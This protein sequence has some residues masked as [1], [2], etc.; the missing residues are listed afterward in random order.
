[1]KKIISLLLIVTLGLLFTL[2]VNAAITITV[3]SSGKVTNTGT[4]SVINVESTDVFLAYKI[5]DVKYDATSNIISY[6]FTDSFAPYAQ[7]KN[8]TVDSYMNLTTGNIHTGSTQTNSTLDALISGYVNYIK[9][10]NITGT[11]MNVTSTTASASLP[12]G[13]YLVLPSATDKVYAVMVGNI[14]VTAK[15]D[16]TWDISADAIKAKKSS[17]SIN[18]IVKGKTA[19]E[20]YN[21]GD[22]IPFELTATIPT[23]PTNA[24]NKVVVIEDELKNGLDFVSTVNN[25]IVFDGSVALTNTNG[26]LTNAANQEVGTVAIDGKKLTVTLNP[27]NLANVSIKVEYNAKLNDSA[28][29]ASLGN[30]STATLEYSNNPYTTGTTTVSSDSTI[31]T[32]GIKIIKKGSNSEPL[33]NVVFKLCSDS[34]CNNV[35]ST[36]TTPNNGEVQHKGLASGTYY[37]KEHSVPAGYKIKTEVVSVTIDTTKD[38]TEVSITNE[39]LLLSLPG[40]GGYGIYIYIGVGSALL[41]AGI[42]GFIIANKKKNDKDEEENK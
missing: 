34:A 30:K 37:I 7:T 21:I 36:L 19:N 16:N 11:P 32:Y 4:L 20:S 42:F 35:I 25:V 12:A 10:N 17:A 24:T 29:I 27:N 2:N 3:D 15:T 13:A 5:I 28:T 38:F 1:M 40:T 6:A 33:E 9:T 23:Y 26:V 31:Y 14:V 39:K 41:L 22:N 8:I 18:K